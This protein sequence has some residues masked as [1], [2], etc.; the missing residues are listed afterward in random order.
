MET[1]SLFE[2]VPNFS[3]GRRPDVISAIESAARRAYVLDTDPDPDHNRV[4]ISIA[5]A[6]TRLLDAIL[7][8]VAE[9]VERIDV[10]RHQ[11]VHPRVGAADVVPFVPLGS[12]TLQQCRE[13]AHE[14]GERI[15]S[16]LKVPVHFYGHGED[17]TL[18][19]I[20]SGRVTPSLGGPA[21]HPTAGAV[22]VGA[23]LTLV[24]FNVLLPDADVVTARALA[25]AIRESAG[26]I[27]G[28]QALVFV[29]PGGRVQLSMNLFR[30]AE[31][32][33]EMVI[34]ELE[35]LGVPL[36]A[37]QLV[38]LCPAAM[39]NEAASGRLLEARLAAAAARAAVPR[40]EEAGTEELTAL[41][42]RMSKEATGLAGMAVDQDSLLAGAERAAALLAVLHAA[43]VRDPELDA[44]LDAAAK[45]LRSAVN[46]GT[47]ALYRSRLAALDA[48]LV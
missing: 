20:R 36:G 11:G 28:V 24:A 23:R 39:A 25:R 2:S 9:A 7:A 4:V 27:R 46:E 41:A 32:T 6:R 42:V 14:A 43:E 45:G 3:E 19:D 48:R 40:C 26:G 44:M 37:Q 13:L 17:R 10:T 34:A 5:G 35:R 33:P 29:L 16:E 12:T 8:S 38:G 30:A 22:C 18:A 47:E 31:T 1:E 15:W 21:P